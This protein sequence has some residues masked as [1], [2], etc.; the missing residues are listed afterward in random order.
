M[1]DVREKDKDFLKQAEGQG[2]YVTSFIEDGVLKIRLPK[3]DDASEIY[4]HRDFMDFMKFIAF[5]LSRRRKE[6]Q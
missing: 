3:S 1:K 6:K 4:N 5:E 2:I